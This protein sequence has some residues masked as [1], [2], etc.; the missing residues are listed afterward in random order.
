MNTMESLSLDSTTVT[1][2]GLD[3]A[4]KSPP[5]PLLDDLNITASAADPIWLIKAEK[6]QSPPPNS[7]LDRYTCRS[8]S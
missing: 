8:T 4:T 3:I 1:T 5:L 6:K 7:S 2:P